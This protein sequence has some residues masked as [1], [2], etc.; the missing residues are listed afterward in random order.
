[1][2]MG[3]QGKQCRTVTKS[4]DTGNERNKAKLAFSPHDEMPLGERRMLSIPLGQS[5][6]WWL[7][8]LTS[9]KSCDD[10]SRFC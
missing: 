4:K 6:T 5:G 7:W 1:M 8:W 10:Q 9:G 2:I 3:Y